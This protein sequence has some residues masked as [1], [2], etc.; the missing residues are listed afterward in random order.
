ME[1][2]R[3][4]D[5]MMRS[6]WA[7]ASFSND[8]GAWET[9]AAL[10]INDSDGW[11]HPGMWAHYGGRHRR[12]GEGTLSGT[13]LVFERVA[14]VEAA[15]AAHK[16]K[17]L[18]FGNIRYAEKDDSTARAAMHV[19]YEKYQELGLAEYGCAHIMQF[20][21]EYHLTKFAGWSYENEARLAINASPDE[22]CFVPFGQALRQVLIGEGATAE[23]IA[24]IERLAATH[25][26]QVSGVRWRNGMPVRV[27]TDLL[28]R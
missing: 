7:F 3:D 14:L 25:G 17:A 18:I 2:S 21:R 27:P 11:Q 26:V 10:D 8:K 20:W 13:V 15:M 4:L 6:H 28:P 1:L 12:A 19:S 22:P 24:E 23:E 9:E 16:D 5:R